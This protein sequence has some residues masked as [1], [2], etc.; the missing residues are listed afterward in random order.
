MWVLLGA[1][2]DLDQP[3]EAR[4]ALAGR[5]PAP[6]HVAAGGAGLVQVDREHVQMLVLLGEQQPAEGHVAAGLGDGELEVLAHQ[7]PAE[8]RGS[9]WQ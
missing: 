4:A 3:L 5:G 2:V 1:G 9:Q 7:V 6:V 8:Q